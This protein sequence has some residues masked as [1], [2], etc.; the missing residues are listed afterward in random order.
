MRLFNHLACSK[1]DS[2]SM[3]AIYAALAAALIIMAPSATRPASAQVSSTAP[4]DASSLAGD[5]SGALDVQGIQLRLVLHVA[6]V[7]GKV[8]ATLDSL[9]QD[10]MAIPVS[11]I[12]RTGDKVAFE[13][14]A[15]GGNY[16]GVLAADGKSVAG[17]W[18][19]GG[20]ELPLALKR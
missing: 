2:D 14:D 13:I 11:A 16:A 1:A 20:N 3:T 7:D 8:S 18:T 4:A 19:Q 17:T 15:V 10:A 12:N 6:S 5:W 9:D